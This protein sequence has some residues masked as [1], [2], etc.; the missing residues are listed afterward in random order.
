MNEQEKHKPT[1]GNESRLTDLEPNGEVVGG[2]SRLPS[3]PVVDLQLDTTSTDL[4]AGTPTGSV[5][6]RVDGGAL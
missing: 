1:P 2:S 3:V 4:G 6:F 5:V